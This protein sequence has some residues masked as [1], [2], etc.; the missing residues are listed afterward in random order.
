[1]FTKNVDLS[2]VTYSNFSFHVFIGGLEVG[3]HIFQGVSDLHEVELAEI[4][5]LVQGKKQGKHKFHIK[6]TTMMER[7]WQHAR[8][9]W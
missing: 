1:M 9:H 8:W 5:E 2:S 6:L 7:N 3:D 4:V